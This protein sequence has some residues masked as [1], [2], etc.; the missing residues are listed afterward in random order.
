MRV[1]IWLRKT[2]TTPERIVQVGGRAV[3]HAWARL[4]VHRNF[5]NT[6]YVVTDRATGCTVTGYPEP[7]TRAAIAQARRRLSLVEKSNYFEI[8]SL[9]LAQLKQAGLDLNQK[10]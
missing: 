6:G 1:S 4:A 5:E 3:P 7:T 2:E 8:Q 9:V 10:K